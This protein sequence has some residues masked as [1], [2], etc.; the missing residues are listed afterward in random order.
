MPTARSPG[1]YIAFHFM[2]TTPLKGVLE[3]KMTA[4]R[5]TNP[6]RNARIGVQRCGF[7]N[8]GAIRCVRRVRGR[9]RPRES[10]RPLH[11]ADNPNFGCDPT[12]AALPTTSGR[13]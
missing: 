12:W 2:D 3:L 4:R 9:P 10:A 7:A 11:L 13:E 8:D 6:K 1:V 5:G